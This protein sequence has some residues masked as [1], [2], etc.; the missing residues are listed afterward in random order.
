MSLSGC[1]GV[2]LDA[3]WVLTAAHCV[4]P[5]FWGG[6]VSYSRKDPITGK[7]ETGSRK[8]NLQYG[9]FIHPAYKAGGGFDSP[10]ND[11]ALVRLDSP[12]TITPLLQTVAL[13]SAPRVIGRT[14]TIAAFSHS[15]PN[16]PAGSFAIY[17]TQIPATSP[18]GCA[19][20]N[21]AFC[22]V[23]TQAALC[24]GDSGSG[25][26]TIENGRATVTGVASYAK[27]ASCQV[28]DNNAYVGLTDVYSFRD[29]ILATMNT[30]A[31]SLAGN[32]R[33]RF[34]G[35]F[36]RGVMG[37]GCPNPYDTMW[38]PLDVAGVQEGAEC[39]V[40]Q[41]QTVICSLQGTQSLGQIITGFTMR[42]ISPSGA[43]SIQSLPFSSTWASYYGPMA[44][45]VVR[46]F[47]CQIGLPISL[48]PGPIGGGVLSP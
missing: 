40:G 29:W 25:F 9:V 2:L 22:V 32:T 6:T 10:E 39:E 12:F 16:L 36:A 4:T 27:S 31:A 5:G 41:S 19:P 33:V 37:V 34:S 44:A 26:V 30:S 11:I 24:P 14:G 47:T 13:P 28:V 17:R 8:A 43:S 23:S 3:R 18:F 42:T 45:G 46:E 21:G 7:T 15:N 20:P 38:G 1:R 35:K 48:P